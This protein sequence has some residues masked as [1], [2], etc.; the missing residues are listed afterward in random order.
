M[1]TTATIEKT[2]LSTILY[3]PLIIKDL[4]INQ[5]HF[6]SIGYR[7]VFEIIIKLYNKNLP[8]DVE[9][10]NKSSKNKYENELI[11][12]ISTTPIAN[13]KAY[14]SMLIEETKK[15]VLIELLEKA[16]SSIND[17]PYTQVYLE[18]EKALSS[19]LELNL[20]SNSIKIDNIQNIKA[21]KPFFYLKNI[22]PIQKNE[23]N[24]FSSKGVQEKVGLYYI[25]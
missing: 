1:K 12:I 13:F 15:R 25:F 17:L 14:E 5:N 11:E 9:F 8:I 21:T 23:I 18:L 24:L 22:L 10:I 6:N 19:N 16:K 4:K 7:G 20:N 3:E 2:I